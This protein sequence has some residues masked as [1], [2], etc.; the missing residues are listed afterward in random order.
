MGMEEAPDAA[1]PIEEPDARRVV[2]C[3][4]PHRD[5]QM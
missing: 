3:L 1:P 5:T 4:E 2:R